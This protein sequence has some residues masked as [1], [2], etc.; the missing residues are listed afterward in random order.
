MVLLD[1]Y[2][3]IW[4][5]VFVFL[6]LQNISTQANTNN[7]IDELDYLSETEENNLQTM[8][9]EM[10]NAYMLDAVIV[11]TD[12]VDGKSSQVF[13]EEF[14]DVNEYG[15]GTEADG[16]IMLINMEQ[17]ELWM[18]TTGRMTIAKYEAQIDRIVGNVTKKLKDENYYDASLLFLEEIKYIEE[19]TGLYEK[20]YEEVYEGQRLS[21]S[22]LNPIPYIF[23]AIIAT[24]ATVM[25]TLSNKGESI[26]NGYTYEKQNGFN[27]IHQQDQF[28]RQQTTKVKINN[29]SSSSGGSSGSSRSHGGGGGSF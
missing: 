16:I 4:I 24:V 19:D 21:D 1:K 8:I 28:I 29:G 7:V 23:I 6:A 18:S 22:L 10:Q 3:K 14:Y 5:V 15:I 11:I 27:L 26:T 25:I 20:A 12:Q 17:R 13:A 9:E 2:I